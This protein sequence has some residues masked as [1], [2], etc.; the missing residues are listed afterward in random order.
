MATQFRCDHCDST[1]VA[2]GAGGQRV[3]CGRCG[4][5][6]TIPQ[7]LA[8]LPMPPGAGEP[9]NP[10]QLSPG[11]LTPEPPWP[12]EAEVPQRMGVMDRLATSFP[13]V[14]SVFL[15]VT[16][17]LTLALIPVFMLYA[18]DS[19]EFTVP[20]V[21]PIVQT[22]RPMVDPPPIPPPPG[23][24][25]R[26]NRDRFSPQPDSAADDSSNPLGKQLDVAIIG[27]G[28]HG[29]TDGT[30][31]GIGKIGGP[32]GD[33]LFEPSTDGTNAKHVVFLIDRSGSM[34]NSF[35]TLRF[36]L[37]RHIAYLQGHQTFHVIFFGSQRG[38]A[39]MEIASR[40]MTPATGRF[41]SD[42]LNFLETVD[43][44]G[45]TVCAPALERALRALAAIDDDGGK[46][47]Y[48]LTDGQLNDWPEPLAVTRRLNATNDV[49]IQTF[50]YSETP[51]ARAK[52]MLET[53]AAENAG[54]SYYVNPHGV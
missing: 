51:D 38:E 30:G 35:G 40:R 1:L 44:G 23:P 31:V 14:M 9:L 49:S 15:N 53:L 43:T 47:I 45:Q 21:N 33:R 37:Q 19:R 39:P 11:P 46:V 34:Y 7:G 3:A 20:G 2:D 54:Q 4:G 29:L 27:Q 18:A 13:W 16:I 17:L 26:P 10:G 24:V 50:L 6:M 42:A 52:Q 8:S 22:I 5:E 12:D 36:E 41:K 32:P 48:L 25:E 28:V